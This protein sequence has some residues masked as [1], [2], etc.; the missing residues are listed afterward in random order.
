MS[1]SH[2]GAEFCNMNNQAVPTVTRSTGTLKLRKRQI[3]PSDKDGETGEL[4]GVRKKGHEGLGTEMLRVF[5]IE[6]RSVNTLG[7]QLASTCSHWK[8][9]YYREVRYFQSPCGQED[10][11]VGARTKIKQRRGGS[12]GSGKCQFYNILTVDILDGKTS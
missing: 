10:K 11:D 2:V 8:L 3:S 1:F 5:R 12:I 6:H 9:K 4:W 7:L